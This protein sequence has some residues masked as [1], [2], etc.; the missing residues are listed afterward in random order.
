MIGL[1]GILSATFSN[2]NLLGG[3]RFERR[4]NSTKKA[5]GIYFHEAFLVGALVIYFFL[6]AINAHS[7]DNIPKHAA[8]SDGSGIT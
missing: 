3:S 4:L 6:L 7:S 8:I 2:K 1:S 5:S